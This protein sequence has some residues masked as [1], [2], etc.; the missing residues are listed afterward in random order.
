MT[1]EKVTTSDAVDKGT[2]NLD[3]KKESVVTTPFPKKKYLQLRR[4]KQETR[5]TKL[6]NIWM[7]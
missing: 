5:L 7:I 3:D 2:K 4:L 6:L 1:T